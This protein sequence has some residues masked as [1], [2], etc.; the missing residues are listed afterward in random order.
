MGI[1]AKAINYQEQSI[2]MHSDTVTA[3]RLK[4]VSESKK[5]LKLTFQALLDNPHAIDLVRLTLKGL[6]AMEKATRIYQESLRNRPELLRELGKADGHHLCL[7][8]DSLALS[9]ALILTEQ[10]LKEAYDN[11]T[12][13]YQAAK[14]AKEQCKAII[15]L[16]VEGGYTPDQII[17]GLKK[18]AYSKDDQTLNY[19]TLD[20]FTRWASQIHKEYHSV[21]IEPSQ[22]TESPNAPN[23]SDSV[24]KSSDDTETLPSTKSEERPIQSE[25]VAI[26]PP[27]PGAFRKFFANTIPC[28]AGS[29]KD[30]IVHF[31]TSTV[32]Y[33]TGSAKDGIVH[34]TTSTVPY[35]TGSAKDGIVHFT[36][37]TVP[38]YTGSAKDGIVHFTTSTVPYY[39]GSAKDGIVH[40]TTSTVP[41]S[42]TNNIS[43]PVSNT[44]SR[45]RNT[46]NH[47]FTSVKDS[48]VHFSTSTLPHSFSTYIGS[49]VSKTV[50]GVWN[51]AKHYFISVKNSSVRFSTSTVPHSFATYIGS[52][53]SNAVNRVW[54]AARFYFTSAKN[55]IV[56]TSKA[57]SP[58]R[59]A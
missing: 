58:V 42:F 25:P 55:G 19:R 22:E 17:E 12:P 59:S 54:N 56:N 48:S 44:L 5:S 26:L 11:L 15:Q 10:K 20:R 13:Q 30:G 18:E 8:W 24:E 28:L 37:S 38:Y 49:P 32:P 52:P 47:Y 53:V 14:K 7:T 43:S 57:S 45:V 29:A 9:R 21:K 3:A 33:Y 41:H 1:F 50:S 31:T 46:A 16:A 27:T 36:T 39:T 4:T 2:A 40:F 23:T 51:T 35:Y 34:F 6:P